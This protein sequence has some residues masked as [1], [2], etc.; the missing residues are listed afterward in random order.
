MADLIP[1]ISGVDDP[2]KVRIALVQGGKVVSAPMDGVGFQPEDAGLTD[3]AG[4]AVTDGNIIVGDGTNWVAESG[5]TARTSLGVSQA[6][7]TS[8]SVATTSGTSIDFT[9]IPAGVTRVTIG[10]SGVSTNNTANLYLQIGD[11]GGIETSGYLGSKTVMTAAVSSSNETAA[12]PW[13]GN[14]AA[15]VYH[16]GLT[17]TLIN[18]ATNLW[19]CVGAVG[20][21]SSAAVVVTGGTKPLSATL[22]RVRLTTNGGVDTFD[23]GS[24][25]ISWE[26]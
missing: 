1:A 24:A 19:A 15:N 13:G 6:K 22:D 9:G 26:F 23:A 17:L 21:S 5:A 16:G 8:A 20:L 14:A 10:L 25:N 11:S 3:I 18:S 2:T 12:F 7:S 4:L